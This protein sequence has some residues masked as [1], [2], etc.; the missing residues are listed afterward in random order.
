MGHGT[1]RR[2]GGGEGGGGREFVIA[3]DGHWR[4]NSAD[5]II[6]RVVLVTSLDPAS[7][8]NSVADNWLAEEMK[9]SSD[10]Q[11]KSWTRV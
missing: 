9:S 2:A 5:L 1:G 6:W 4:V 10:D 11:H 3:A 7:A 8:R